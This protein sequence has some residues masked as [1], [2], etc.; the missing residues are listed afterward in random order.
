MAGHATDRPSA[1]L[2]SLESS[3]VSQELTAYLMAVRSYADHFASGQRMS[4]RKHLR[5]V[6][7]E[8]SRAD[9]RRSRRCRT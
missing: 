7:G 5:M 4:F 9:R 1:Y 8:V 2:D 6:I 3:R